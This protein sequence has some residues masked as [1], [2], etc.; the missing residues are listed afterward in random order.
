MS[1]SLLE[2]V[3]NTIRIKSINL[4]PTKHLKKT[5]N[6]TTIPISIRRTRQHF[7]TN[8][9]KQDNIVTLRWRNY[10]K[11]QEKLNIRDNHLLRYN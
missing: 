11:T 4:K 5:E 8:K 10:I 7:R 1:K 3:I 9:K 6:P 2:F